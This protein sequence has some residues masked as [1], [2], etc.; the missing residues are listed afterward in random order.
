MDGIGWVNFA[1]VSVEWS[2][3][4][5]SDDGLDIEGTGSGKRFVGVVYVCASNVCVASRLLFLDPF[6][7]SMPSIFHDRFAVPV[8][9]A[10]DS[11]CVSVKGV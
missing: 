10:V 4:R 11:G 1:L 6:M 5:L 9:F 7:F 2:E 8:S 3:T